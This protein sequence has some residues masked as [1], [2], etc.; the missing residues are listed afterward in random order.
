MFARVQDMTVDGD[1][2]PGTP[3][4]V[5]DYLYVDIA[6]VRSLLAQMADG[7]PDTVTDKSSRIANATAKMALGPIGA[8]LGRNK[9][10][11]RTESRSLSDLTFSLFEESAESLGL[12]REASDDWSTPAAWHSGQVQA[13]LELSQLIRV[14]APVR[15][16]DPTHFGDSISRIDSML[17]AFV[18]VP[19]APA[20]PTQPGARSTSQ[21]RSGQGGSQKDRILSDKKRALLGD[22]APEMLPALSSLVQSLLAGGI[23]MRCTPCGTEKP[24]CSFSGIL[25][26]RSD[27]IEPERAAV[28]GRYGV[29]ASPWTLVG[30]VSRFANPDDNE[31]TPRVPGEFGR[32]ALEE[33][34]ASLLK[35]LEAIGVADAPT[36]PS[37]AITPLGLYRA[38]PAA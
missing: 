6:R 37:I 25:L 19:S 36:W 29:E 26:N 7:A 15:L 27:Y 13:D 14:T 18:S 23:S 24:E 21:K 34:V 30:I 20:G 2:L 17:D 16:I 35:K 28:F 12:L 31:A 38:L 3:A 9:G 5:R 1:V 11:E 32:L 10:D 4:F 8:D 22:A 33:M